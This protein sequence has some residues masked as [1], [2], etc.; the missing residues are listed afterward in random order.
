MSTVSFTQRDLRDGVCKVF[1]FILHIAGTARDDVLELSDDTP[2]E[3]C[4]EAVERKDTE[5]AS[6]QLNAPNAHLGD[7]VASAYPQSNA[8]LWH[9]NRGKSQGKSASVIGDVSGSWPEEVIYLLL[10]A[11]S[12]CLRLHRYSSC[13]GSIRIQQLTLNL[14]RQ[15]LGNSWEIFPEI[16]GYVFKCR[17]NTRKSD[18]PIIED[19]LKCILSNSNLKH[20]ILS[21]T[22]I[23]RL[24]R[25][26]NS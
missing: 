16:P 10:G 3:G 7:R 9:R 12:R 15:H 5:V 8:V 1:W 21:L 26:G 19:F 6:T 2:W 18:L 20:T 24:A 23:K 25:D 13:G 11:I 17:V 4:E 22:R 14:V